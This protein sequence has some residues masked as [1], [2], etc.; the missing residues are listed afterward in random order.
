[1]PGE[2]ATAPLPQ[3]MSRLLFHDTH[4]VRNYGVTPPDSELRS[5][6]RTLRA[7]PPTEVARFRADDPEDGKQRPKICRQK[8]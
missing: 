4:G 5:A 6:Q 3:T 1:M 2:S 8:A 7:P